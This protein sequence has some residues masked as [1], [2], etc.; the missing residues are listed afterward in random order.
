MGMPC[1]TSFEYPRPVHHCHAVPSV[2]L[3]GLTLAV[4]QR[5]FGTHEISHNVDPDESR[6]AVLRLAPVKVSSFIRFAWIGP[7]SFAGVT[8]QIAVPMAGLLVGPVVEPP[9]GRRLVID[10]S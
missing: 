1:F 6:Y 10:R 9:P 8:V 4:R 3:S 7:W 2:A 5:P